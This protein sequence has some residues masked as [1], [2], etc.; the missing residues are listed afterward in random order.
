[1]IADLHQTP[2]RLRDILGG[3][4][5]ATNAPAGSSAAT[6]ILNSP[7]ARAALAGIAAMIVKRVMHGPER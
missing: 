1:V 7:L 6:S 4:G 3:G 2:G 5:D